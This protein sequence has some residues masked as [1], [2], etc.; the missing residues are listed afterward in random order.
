MESEWERAIFKQTRE[1]D[2][3]VSDF[4]NW[5][6]AD[7]R[8]PLVVEFKRF[9]NDLTDRP[10]ARYTPWTNDL[11]AMLHD[12]SRMEAAMYEAAMPAD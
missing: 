4:S 10:S 6:V 7:I 3:L 8:K 11:R 5:G 12:C 2:L 1:G 9:L